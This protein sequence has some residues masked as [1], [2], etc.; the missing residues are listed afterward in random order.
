[1]FQ[2]HF[3]PSHRSAPKGLNEESPTLSEQL[4]TTESFHLPQE[5]KKKKV[6]EIKN[7]LIGK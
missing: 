3:L 1:M 6:E 5:L 2:V 4:K 7:I